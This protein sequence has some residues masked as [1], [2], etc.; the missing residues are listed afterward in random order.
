MYKIIYEL[1]TLL[2]SQVKNEDLINEGIILYTRFY[3][4]KKK[5]GKI[6]FVISYDTFPWLGI[7]YL[8]T[9]RLFYYYKDTNI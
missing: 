9:T 5:K 7:L 8:S 4:R 1:L 6:F 3:Y 2:P